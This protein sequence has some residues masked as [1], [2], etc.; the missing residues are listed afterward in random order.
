MLA[1]SVSTFLLQWNHLD[2]FV[3]DFCHQITYV[4]TLVLRHG[5]FEHRFQFTNDRIT[6]LFVYDYQSL[7]YGELS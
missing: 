3:F 2:Q 1:I 7:N 4:T 5:Y 6:F